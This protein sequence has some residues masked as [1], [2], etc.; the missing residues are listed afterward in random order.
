M[1]NRDS[2]NWAFLAVFV[3]VLVVNPTALY[4]EGNSGKRLA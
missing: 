3:V 1:L 4:G 2:F